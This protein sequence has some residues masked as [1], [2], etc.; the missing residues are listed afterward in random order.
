MYPLLKTG[1]TISN[2]GFFAIEPSGTSIWGYPDSKAAANFA[3]A[4]WLAGS[5]PSS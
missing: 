1:I 2:F 3:D 5:N 4:R